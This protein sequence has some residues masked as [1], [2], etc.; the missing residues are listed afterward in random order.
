MRVGCGPTAPNFLFFEIFGGVL[1]IISTSL[2]H[3]SSEHLN[4]RFSKP[5]V[6]RTFEGWWMN[7]C[8]LLWKI[9][10]SLKTK[11]PVFQ[12]A[13]IQPV[14]QCKVPSCHAS[15]YSW[16]SLLGSFW[17]QFQ[18]VENF[19]PMKLSVTV[20]PFSSSQVLVRNSQNEKFRGCTS[21][22]PW[23]VCPWLFKGESRLCRQVLGK[24]EEQ[25]AQ[26]ELTYAGPADCIS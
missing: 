15:A 25:L 5:G 7:F 6:D 24:A 19:L 22:F 20:S 3:P 12:K 13:A 4:T 23:N 8:N 21:V 11:N 17:P 1:E 10:Q 18:G 2:S 9:K 26:I 14:T 16:R